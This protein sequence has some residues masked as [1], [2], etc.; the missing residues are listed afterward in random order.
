M[1]IFSIALALYFFIGNTP[2][3][4]AAE[5]TSIQSQM[6]PAEL[7]ASG[8]GKLTDSELQFLNSWLKLQHSNETIKTTNNTISSINNTQE[9]GQSD[10]NRDFTREEA[11][12]ILNAPI[13]TR[14]KGQFTGWA[15][16]TIFY[17]ENGETWKQRK[18]GWYRKK[19]QSP[20]VILRKNYFGFYEMTI[21]ETGRKVGVSRVK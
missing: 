15:G 21:V 7:K 13:R 12:K 20:E 18:D 17:L 6:S 16:N 3:G 9:K 1:R 19:L 10:N 14:I 5:E 8:L 11:E 4:I 2:K